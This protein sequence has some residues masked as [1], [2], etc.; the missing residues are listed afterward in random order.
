MI[1]DPDHPDWKKNLYYQ[2]L[3]QV[4]ANLENYDSDKRIPMYGFG[5]ILPNGE[6]PKIP[7]KINKNGKEEKPI[8]WTSHC[9]AM[10]GDVSD[11]NV[12]GVEGVLRTYKETTPLIGFWGPTCFAPFFK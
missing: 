10:N 12:K 8:E 11:P 2:A 1:E 7:M 5:G 6:D 4:A 9:F 3:E